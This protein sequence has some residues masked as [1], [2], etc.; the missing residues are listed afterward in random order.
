MNNEEKIWEVSFG[1][2]KFEELNG[3][4]QCKCD[5]IT[6]VETNGFSV[7]VSCG[8]ISKQIISDL[9]E[10]GNYS[11][12]SGASTTHSRC[13]YFTKSTEINPYSGTM[14]S[15]IP[16]GVKNVCYVD[17]KMVKYDI[18]KIHVQNVSNHLQKSFNQVENI[19]D[20]AT[21][22]KYSTS[23]S[24]TAKMLWAD[25][26]KSKKVTRAGVRKGLI[27]CCLYYACVHHDCTR[28]PL[29]ICNDFGMKDTIQFNKGDQEFK[30]TFQYNEK[31]GH[32]IRKT[33]K[34][35]DYFNRFTSLLEANHLIKEGMAYKLAN[36][37]REL[38]SS[39]ETKF[40]GMF[41]K[42]VACAI[43]Y[44]VCLNNEICVTKSNISKCLG[45]CS[46]SLNKILNML[47]EV[48]EMSE[49]NER[50]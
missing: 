37:C 36:E 46:P 25:I 20:N 9:A 14:C 21:C 47:N 34:T 24:N 2:N 17:G 18:S 28:S 49:R 13:G 19:I 3:S 42:N 39:V 45:V 32:L 38:Y 30:D 6:F 23:I 11:D 50:I 10:W 27:A 22:Y 15:F 12:S 26:M 43:L 33:S 31:W 7:C 5:S 29:E 8:L 16:K 44:K 1:I 40:I 35:E 41:P 4:N 48:D